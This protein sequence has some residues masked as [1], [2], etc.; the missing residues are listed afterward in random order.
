MERPG[1][2][3]LLVE[4][5]STEKV[6]QDNYHALKLFSLSFEN[7]ELMVISRDPAHRMVDGIE[8][9]PYQR[10]LEKIFFE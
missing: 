9:A 10:A 2:R 8:L 4:I 5:K 3:I 6:I 7:P 1:K